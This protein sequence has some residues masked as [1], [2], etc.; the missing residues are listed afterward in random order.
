MS[1][2]RSA[3]S[4]PRAPLPYAPAASLADKPLPGSVLV[5]GMLL[6]I[7][8]LVAVSQLAAHLRFDVVDDQM[9]G[10]FG[11]RIAH[12]GVVYQDVWDNKPPGIYWINALGFLLG[13]DSYAGVIALCVAALLVTHI[14]FFSVCHSV[15][16]RGA[17]ALGTVLASFFFTHGYFQGGTNRT[18]TFLVAAELLGV[19]LYFRGF[20]RDRAWK[21]LLAGA[22]CGCAFLFK[23]VGLAAMAAMGVHT[24]VLLFTRELSLRTALRRGVLLLIGAALP[25]SAAAGAL[26]WQ[27][28]LDDAIFATFTFNR[29]YFNA[30]NS[31]FTDTFLNRHMLLNH[32]RL[33]FLLPGLM[34]ATALIHS[35]LWWLRPAY[36]PVEVETP[37]RA[38]KPVCPRYMLFFVV[39]WAIAFYG[40][41]VSPHYFRHY[42]VPTIAP[43][44]FVAVYAINVIKTEMSLVRRLVNRAWV[45]GAFVLMGWLAWDSFY[46][47]V[48][49]LSRVWVD[50][51]ERHKQAP[52]ETIAA[53]VVRHSTPEQTIQCWGYFPG[54]YLHSRR[55]A[56]CR[57]TTTEKIGQVKDFAEF[58]RRE[59]YET[60]K[61][62][63]PAVFVVSDED[64]Q[65]FTDPPPGKPR[66]WVGAWLATWLDANYQRVADLSVPENNVY[67]YKRRDLAAPADANLGPPPPAT[68][69]APRTGSQP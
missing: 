51:F 45:V 2:G 42:L 66:D 5:L 37:L 41:M 54:V 56:A 52:W 31:S 44:M 40:A 62:R 24:L 1:E 19:L 12:G 36:R 43:M 63:P 47:H 34:C 64:Y 8:P 32:M 4:S 6:A 22:C 25:V 10:Y 59:L 50:R 46:E 53:E 61:S 55:M 18:E 27:G 15:Y 33:Q 3:D 21:W 58:Q 28:A 69:P 14:C 67:V 38:Q 57:Y 65:W 35:F 30:G 39:W 20:A 60:L 29:A 17:A 23:Q 26:A 13:A 7:A 9:F 49:Q 16:D 48:G 11:W 68:A